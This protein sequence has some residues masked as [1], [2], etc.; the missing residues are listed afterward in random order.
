MNRNVLRIAAI[1]MLAGGAAIFYFIPIA[2]FKL[3]GSTI[4]VLG[5]AIARFRNIQNLY[6]YTRANDRGLPVLRLVHRRSISFRVALVSFSAAFLF[7]I[8]IAV[9]GG[10][11]KHVRLI[12][13]SIAVIL[14]SVATML[15]VVGANFVTWYVAYARA[16]G[17][18]RASRSIG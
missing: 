5:L 15:I 16:G 17:F 2:G 8:L 11:T 4:F 18:K 12:L 6:S 7:L 10:H 14:V 1:A 9:I 13:V 3:V